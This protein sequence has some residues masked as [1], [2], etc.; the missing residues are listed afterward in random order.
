MIPMQIIY[1]L[2]SPYANLNRIKIE[3]RFNQFHLPHFALLLLLWSFVDSVAQLLVFA[4]QV[5]VHSG[6]NSPLHLVLYVSMLASCF[7]Y[8]ID[9]TLLP[10]IGRTWVGPILKSRI[11]DQTKLLK[12][13]F[14]GRLETEGHWGLQLS[15]CG[16][17]RWV[18]SMINHDK[19]RHRYCPCNHPNQ[20][21]VELSNA[22]I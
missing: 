15:M 6:L 8:Y 18:S 21:F 3:Q 19:P 22:W 7:I 14:L 2:G 9:W 10:N 16:M 4:N 11:Q 17:A 12:L 20:Y 1:N 13:R 5:C